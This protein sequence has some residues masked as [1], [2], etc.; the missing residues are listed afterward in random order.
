MTTSSPPCI[1]LFT[2]PLYYYDLSTMRHDHKLTTISYPST[3]MKSS[4]CFR[5]MHHHKFT[6]PPPPPPFIRIHR[7]ATTLAPF[8]LSFPPLFAP[9]IIHGGRFKFLNTLILQASSYNRF[10][11]QKHSQQ[12]PR[13][14][15]L[16]PSTR[17][18][19]R[20]RYADGHRPSG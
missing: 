15:V 20:N 3:T 17:T 8:K 7:Q 12:V 18:T 2:K 5:A 9:K 16:N 10:H 6:T 14:L 4:P 13:R 11:S 1:K 19:G